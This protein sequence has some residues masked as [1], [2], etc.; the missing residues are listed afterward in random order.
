MYFKPFFKNFGPKIANTKKKCPLC[1]E[2]ALKDDLKIVRVNLFP[3]FNEGNTIQFTLVIRKKGLNV[4]YDPENGIENVEFSRIIQVNK[5]YIRNIILQEKK[6]LDEFLH[7]CHSS[8]EY[9]YL[10]AIEEAYKI[11]D[12]KLSVLEKIS[13]RSSEKNSEKNF[14]KGKNEEAKEKKPVFLYSK[15]DNYVRKFVDKNECLEHSDQFYFI[16]QESEGQLIFL[17]PLNYKYL[18]IEYGTSD[19]LPLKIDGKIQFIDHIT[20]T[21]KIMQRYKFLSHLPQNT[22]A[23]FV[24]I[25]MDN[26]LNKENLKNYKFEVLLNIF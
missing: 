10:P 11:S 20:L 6:E 3:M 1:G 19:H 22:D 8:Q 23:K 12:S 9:D 5:E 14:G 13:E 21:D 26:L 17:H 2:V 16:Y 25:F 18:M 7:L 24:E 15:N 4:I